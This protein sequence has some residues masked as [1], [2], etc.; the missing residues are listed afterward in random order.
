MS[1]GLLALALALVLSMAP[2]ADGAV[3]AREAPGTC[4]EH[5]R[6]GGTW[7]TSCRALPRLPPGRPSRAV[8]ERMRA[9][10]PLPAPLEDTA[11]TTVTGAPLRLRPARPARAEVVLTSRAFGETV[12]V[13]AVPETARWE[14][15][16]GS[17]F[18]CAVPE[19]GCAHTYTRPSGDAPEGAFPLTLTLT[20]S[21]SWYDG[22]G[23]GGTLEPLSTAAT[24]AV[25]V[26]HVE[27][28]LA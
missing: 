2:V 1:R 19:I 12:T 26:R 11:V 24:R 3:I 18:T 4:D 17:A 5:S 14:T 22:D 8:A 6:S 23:N 27:A 10:M 16:E 28:L 20:W 21:L 9:L 7:S 15:G 25:R 13:V